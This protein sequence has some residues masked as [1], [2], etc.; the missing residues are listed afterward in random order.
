[1]LD[2]QKKRPTE[3]PTDRRVDFSQLI[4]K[5]RGKPQT[6]KILFSFH[7]PIAD[8]NNFFQYLAA[9]LVQNT[10]ISFLS[11]IYD[12]LNSYLPIMTLNNLSCWRFK[13][14][15]TIFGNFFLNPEIFPR[16][17]DVWKASE[18]QKKASSNQRSS[19]KEADEEQ[20]GKSF[21]TR[22]VECQEKSSWRFLGACCCQASCNWCWWSLCSAGQPA[23]HVQMPRQSTRSSSF[24]C[25]DAGQESRPLSEGNSI[26]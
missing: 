17:C 22:Q 4:R 16:P 26:L 20:T 24:L 18:V 7:D 8:Q 19:S 15:F 1:M 21:S 23:L 14:I 2:Q 6:W 11:T 12:M 9:N 5:E 25:P 10:P 3:R 13:N